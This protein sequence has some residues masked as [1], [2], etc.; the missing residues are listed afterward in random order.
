[1]I[2]TEIFP[3][4]EQLL[5]KKDWDRLKKNWAEMKPE[6]IAELLKNFASK[7]CGSCLSVDF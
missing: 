4:V 5:D 7:V 3:D 6:D 2:N 1:M